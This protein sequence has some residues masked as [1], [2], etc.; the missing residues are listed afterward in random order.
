MTSLQEVFLP[1]FIVVIFKCNVLQRKIFAPLSNGGR[2]Q[3]GG[4]QNSQEIMYH[5]HSSTYLTTSMGAE[6]LRHQTPRSGL[7][8]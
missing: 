3:E 1:D 6:S 2:E 4:V 7:A 8:S 5:S